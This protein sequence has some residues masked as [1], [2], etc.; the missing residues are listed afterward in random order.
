MHPVFV[1]VLN[2][3]MLK[4][5]QDKCFFNVFRAVLLLNSVLMLQF[6]ANANPADTLKRQ[7]L[8]EVVI[9][10]ARNIQLLSPAPVQVLKGEELERINSL[11]V[12]DALRYFSG[13][14]LKDYGGVGGLKTINVRSM[15]TQHTAVFYDGV[16]LG[17]AQNGQ[18][19]LGKFS[20][21]NLEEISLYNGQ[22]SEIL[23][24][25]GSF[26]SAS[27]VFLRS[28][29]PLFAEETRLNTQFNIKTGSFGLINPSLLLQYKL[30]DHTSASLNTGFS[31]AHGKYKFRYSNGDYDTSVVRSNADVLSLRIET[32]LHGKLKNEGEWNV[33]FYAYNSERGLPGA[34]VSNRFDYQQRLWDK[35][36]FL[37]SAL[38][39][40]VN[41]KYSIML[42]AKYADDYLRYL[43]PEIT[44]NTGFLENVYKE[45]EAYFS[46]ANRYRLRSF[47]DI[48]FAVDYR[49]NTMHA[50]LT[51]FPYPHRNTILTALATQLKFSCLNIQLNALNTWVKDEVETGATSV[52]K[53]KLTPAIMLSWQP[54][55]H[56]DFRL[57]GF[58]KSI[59][60]LPTFNDIYFTQI[61]YRLLKP[62]YTQQY[63]LGFT[64]FKNYNNISLSGVELQADAYYNKVKD[65]IIA[66][67][68]NSSGIWSMRNLGLVVIKGLEINLKSFWELGR[69]FSLT[70][71]L[72]YTH[73][74]ATDITDKNSPYY[75]DQIPYIPLHSGTFTLALD[76]LKAGGINYSFIYTG[77]RYNQAASIP[78]NYVEPWYT[79]D[80]SAFY[81]FK[82]NRKELKIT[83]E[84]NNLLNQYYDIVANFPM[85]GRNYRITLNYK[86]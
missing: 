68:G 54:F 56:T 36:L 45:K 47:W 34:V 28:K 15:G 50:N 51:N 65:K 83:A 76:Y 49:Y 57:R 38:T 9:S 84:L 11:S 19:D 64:F 71:G 7:T 67:P 25:A 8:D 62:E 60:R 37:Q 17:N 42:N 5:K 86:L 35:N 41:K 79:H 48:A 53:Q 61:G 74:N 12:A 18:V 73:Q 52:E 63:D 59:F 40:H 26:A 2:I 30:S 22:K 80:F 78:A 33:K 55:L 72:S 75:G 16:Q 10:S 21:D 4:R 31:N 14:Q 32:G 85:P 58:Y 3:K 46:F 69:K 13:I 66:Q 82:I 29:T 44:T 24:S 39:H 70:Q 43:D 20:L 6:S 1:I 23:Q 77:E 81:R 27:S